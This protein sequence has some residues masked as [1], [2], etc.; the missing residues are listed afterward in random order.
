MKLTT[1]RFRLVTMDLAYKLAVA[2]AGRTM[3]VFDLNRV[4]HVVADQYMMEDKVDRC[5]S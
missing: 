1:S 5:S 2:S 3:I 4:A